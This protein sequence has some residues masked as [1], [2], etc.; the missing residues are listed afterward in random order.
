M[1]FW[2][3]STISTRKSFMMQ[4]FKFSG[5]PLGHELKI[6]SVGTKVTVFSISSNNLFFF[7]VFFGIL[8][9]I[10][11]SQ[12]YQNVFLINLESAFNREV[13]VFR[14]FLVLFLRIVRNEF[15][16]TVCSFFRLKITFYADIGNQIK[17]R[18]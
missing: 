8:R 17:L 3:F 12:K 2:R 4:K 10:T 1:N 9:Q 11:S 13:L 6:S 15:I 14:F 7:H 18:L 16:E 5:I